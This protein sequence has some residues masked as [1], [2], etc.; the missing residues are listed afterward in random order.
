MAR[1][2]LPPAASCRGAGRARA[3]MTH[4]LW[5]SLL[6]VPQSL[7]G[8]MPELFLKSFVAYQLSRVNQQGRHPPRKETRPVDC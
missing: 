4:H 7:L 5:N 8:T 3:F 1:L 2:P 6:S